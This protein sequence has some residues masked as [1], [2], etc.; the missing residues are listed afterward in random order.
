MA[1][2]PAYTL[3]ASDG[4]GLR[5]AYL[6]ARVV[7]QGPLALTQLRLAFDNPQDRTIEGR[8]AVTLPDGAAVSRFAMKIGEAW[9]EGEVVER[10]TATRIYE[11]F[12]HRR[13]DPALLEHDAG[14]RFRARVFP[15]RPFERKE[16]IISYTQAQTDPRAPLRLP[17]LGLPRLD[18]LY[19]R[20][21]FDEGGKERVVNFVRRGYTPEGDLLLGEASPPISTGVRSASI[22]GARVVL[23]ADPDVAATASPPITGWTVLLDTSASQAVGFA[24]RVRGLRPLIAELA[25]RAGRDVEIEVVAFDQERVTLYRGPASGFGDKHIDG[26]ITRG[27]LGASDLAGALLGAKRAEAGWRVLLISDGIATI[28]PTH[29]AAAAATELRAAGAP[30]I[31]AVVTGSASD[32]TALRAIVVPA[33]TGPST[34]SVVDGAQAVRTLVDRLHAP[35]LYGVDVLVPGSLRV[36]PA[37]LDGVQPGDAVMIYAELAEGTPLRVRF[38]GAPLREQTVATASIERPLLERAWRSAQIGELVARHDRLAETDAQRAALRAEIVDLSLAHRV[39]S[40]FTAMLV[41]ETEDDYRRFQLDRRALSDILVVGDAGVEVLRRDL[42]TTLGAAA[43][44]GPGEPPAPLVAPQELAAV[45]SDGDSLNDA[46]DACPMLPEDLDG[47]ADW[48]GCPDVLSFDSCQ[49]KLSDKIYFARRSAALDPRTRRALRDVVDTLNA[50]PDIDLWVDGHADSKEV[51]TNKRSKHLSQRRVAAVVD[52]LVKAGIDPA[53]LEP[54]GMG[55]EV[56]IADN[57]TTEGRA[58]NRRVEFNLKE[59]VRWPDPFVGASRIGAEPPLAGEFQAV[60][61]ALQRDP[62]EALRLARA[63]WDAQPGDVLAAIALGRAYA[64]AGQ[65]TAA[66]RAY[67]SLIDLSPSRAE[68]RRH[69][70]QRLEAIGAIDLAVDTYRAAALQ[71]PD[72][73]TSH[74]LL[75]FALARLGRHAEAFAALQVGLA[76]Q[77]PPGRFTGVESILRE[78]LT[79]LG[80]AW[81]RSEPAA[82]PE[83]ERQLSAHGLSPASRSSLRF[84][85]MWEADATNVDLYVRDAGGR[86]PRS[87]LRGTRGVRVG[88]AAGYGPELVVL[89]DP[90]RNYPYTVE[91]V[92]TGRGAMGHA[93]GVVQVLEH[94]GHGRLG[95]STLPFVLMNE[96]AGLELGMV[97]GPLVATGG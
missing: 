74:R 82:R 33:L 91:V 44:P 38:S 24:Q 85:L 78:D 23:A 32:P 7:V 67:G 64:G 40:P 42:A 92:Y 66:A 36:W 48:D 47:V 65:R 89:T 29:A 70:G 93:M 2:P 81:I 59:C 94:D 8:F 62:A 63:W 83:V 58:A 53:R 56:P 86:S 95:F 75:A 11:S 14:N 5:L 39:L 79:I 4:T 80:A 88:T 20:L 16:L 22:V 55:E 87:N 21:I 30:R 19:V 68:F 31:D 84:A 28:G 43:K 1:R 72:H 60:D 26:A 18:A 50:A 35:N 57:R 3:T 37:R 54:R 25:A 49:V 46:I 17:L 73:P 77:Y 9:Q 61:A 6:D 12:L 96:R 51:D 71:R 90:G 97:A 27:A 76:Q 13:V 41:L 45:D 52:H 69:A 34:G 10:L 15:I